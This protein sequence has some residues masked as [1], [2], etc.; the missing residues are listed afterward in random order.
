[1]EVRKKLSVFSQ[2]Y[3]KLQDN[4][5]NLLLH[6]TFSEDMRTALYF[7]N[8]EGNFINYSKIN[9]LKKKSKECIEEMWNNKEVTDRERLLYNVPN[10]TKEVID[11]SN[12]VNQRLD[13]IFVNTKDIIE[14]L[15]NCSNLT[16]LT[17]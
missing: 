15:G 17:Y 11:K 10:L 16:S 7:T 2:D 14:R 13:K 6:T 1:M 8:I 4:C 3:L 5:F 12:E 9:K